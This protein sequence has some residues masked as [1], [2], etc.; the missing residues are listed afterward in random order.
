MLQSF[1]PRKSIRCNLIKTTRYPAVKATATINCERTDSECHCISLA[2]DCIERSE[3]ARSR[4]VSYWELETANREG[5]E[6][7]ELFQPSPLFLSLSHSRSGNLK[8]TNLAFTFLREL[9]QRRGD[10]NET[11][12]QQ[13]SEETPLR[14][15][16]TSGTRL[17]AR[18]RNYGVDI[19]Q[20][21]GCRRKISTFW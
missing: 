21:R 10:D 7:R 18:P 19:M 6:V 12:F 16:W 17:A 20:I 11:S 2:R 8:D 3:S 4:T 13:S 1:H 9:A 14:F 15:L 5:K